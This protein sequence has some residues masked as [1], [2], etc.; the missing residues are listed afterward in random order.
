M[1][2]LGSLVKRITIGTVSRDTGVPI[3]TMWFY[4]SERVL[5]PACRKLSYYHREKR[6]R[7]KWP[8]DADGAHHGVK[9]AKPGSC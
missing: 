7:E 9:A 5:P 4:E 8:K 3:P 2:G 1:E 6:S